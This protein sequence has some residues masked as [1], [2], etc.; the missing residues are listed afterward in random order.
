MIVRPAVTADIAYWSKQ[1]QGQ[2]ALATQFARHCYF[3]AVTRGPAASLVI[4]PNGPPLVTI[5]AIGEWD[6]AARAPRLEIWSFMAAPARLFRHRFA[7]V[8][9]L[10]RLCAEKAETGWAMHALIGARNALADARFARAFSFEWTGA[11]VTIDQTYRVFQFQE[12]K[13]AWAK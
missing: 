2:P 7:L 9:A 1:P 6:E 12:G 4:E 11:D 8:R 5:G 10:R 13:A 3:A